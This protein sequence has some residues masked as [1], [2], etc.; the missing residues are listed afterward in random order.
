MYFLVHD[1]GSFEEDVESRKEFRAKKTSSLAKLTFE[2]CKV[3][4][5]V[6]KRDDS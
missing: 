1:D 3:A 2:M 6:R 5:P 4:C